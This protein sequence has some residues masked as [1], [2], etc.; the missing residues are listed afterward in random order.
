MRWRYGGGDI[1]LDELGVCE[2][3]PRGLVVGLD[4]RLMI[5]RR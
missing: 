3:F 1:L 4:T 2:D 5:G